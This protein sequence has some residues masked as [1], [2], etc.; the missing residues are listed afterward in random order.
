MSH[1]Y[2]LEKTAQM[3]MSMNVL[4]HERI[5]VLEA[6]NE[7][8]TKKK[9]RRHASLGN[10]LLLSVQEGENRTQQLGL[11]LNEDI[12]DSTPRPRQRAPSRCSGC[13]TIGH[14]IRNCPNK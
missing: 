11:Q 14:T 7:R 6:E 13:G 2:H 1:I 4:L 12:G 5:K 8:K 10:D 9:A 3:Q